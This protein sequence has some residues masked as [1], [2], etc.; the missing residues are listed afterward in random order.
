MPSA[1][2]TIAKT[3]PLPAVENRLRRPSVVDSLGIGIPGCSG[4]K[5]VATTPIPMYSA[6]P[7]SMPSHIL[8]LVTLRISAERRLRRRAMTV[9][10]AAE[11]ARV[12][13]I[14]ALRR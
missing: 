14:T 9:A 6:T 3:Y 4:A 1:P 13:L 12:E 10:P 5:I 8:V 7:M 11:V 2:I